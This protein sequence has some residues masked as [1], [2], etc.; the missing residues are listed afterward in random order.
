MSHA[1]TRPDDPLAPVTDAEIVELYLARDEAAI[2][3]TARIYGPYCLTIALNI[4]N[5][6]P[7]AEECVNDTYLRTWNS[8]P[9]QKP[10]VLRLFLG[11]ITRNLA[12]DR[13]RMKKMRNPEFELTLEEL[14]EILPAPEEDSDLP[15][16]L[17][18]FLESLPEEER[19]LFILRY[20]HG[21]SVARLSKAFRIK[22]NNLSARL[23]RTREKLRTYLTERGYHL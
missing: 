21:H 10:T 3:H 7:D 14:A 6:L 2:R 15:M 4:L 18:E 9:P 22:P 11:K 5:S 20:W 17:A 16:L 8:I 13:Y 12:I 23:Y 1:K 19:G